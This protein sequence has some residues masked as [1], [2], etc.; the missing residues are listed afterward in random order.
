MQ[1]GC[2]V[3]ILNGTIDK[4]TVTVTKI[5][6]LNKYFA[7]LGREREYAWLYQTNE[8]YWLTISSSSDLCLILS[9][10]CCC[11]L[12]LS[13]CSLLY[14]KDCVVSKWVDTEWWKQLHPRDHRERKRRVQKRWN[15]YLTIILFS[16]YNLNGFIP[17]TVFISFREIWRLYCV[18]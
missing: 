14:F 13:T 6:Y 18:R 16:L 5:T 4:D 11:P 2:K 10:S 1:S 8:S 7:A 17:Q 9:R 15:L 12:L 3:M